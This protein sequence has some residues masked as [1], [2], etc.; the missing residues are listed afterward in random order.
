MKPA[1]SFVPYKHTGKFQP[2][3]CDYLDQDSFLSPFYRDFPTKENFRQFISD[4]AKQTTNRPVLVEVLLEQYQNSGIL[5]EGVSYQISKLL[6]QQTF[7]ITTGQQTGIFLGPFYASLKILS[8]IKM[9]EELAISYPDF[10]FIPVFWMATED[11]DVEEISQVWMD[12]NKLSWNTAQQGPVGRFSNEGLLEL[13]DQLVALLGK[14]ADD[15]KLATVFSKAYSL[16]TLADATRYIV[17]SLFGDKGV[18]IID[19][20]DKRLKHPFIPIIKQDIFEKVSFN[21]V[22]STRK[23]LEKRYKSQVHGREINFFYLL[24]G[25][26]NR[27]VQTQ[28]GYSTDDGKYTWLRTELDVEIDSNPER[29]SPNVVMR[30]L[31]QELILPNLA[32]IGGGAEIAYWLELKGIFDSYSIPYPAL[33]LRNSAQLI[34][35]VNSHRLRNSKFSIA[36]LFLN[37]QELE[38][39]LAR[40]ESQDDITL[41][42]EGLIISELVERARL[43]AINTDISLEKAALNL[44]KKLKSQLDK[45]SKKLISAQKRKSFESI[46]RL[47]ALLDHV[48]PN[49]SLQERTESVATFIHRHGFV[50]L[51]ELLENID[52]FENRF[53]T[54]EMK[55]A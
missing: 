33:L 39:R 10:A 40:G 16:G 32:Y 11:H 17:H 38:N 27:I 19:A 29:F 13:T 20:D 34:D 24:D 2:I 51:D 6:D 15:L 9:C 21:A 1:C 48:F 41:Q 55:E 23:L 43:I 22:E 4:K 49:G 30:P 45:F 54:L 31:Y 3:V 7:T 14:S 18:L 26:R 36:D 5:N 28:T 25:Y 35:T 52:P 37:K 47:N 8:A 53:L 50:I 12:G 46:N 42:H 44:E